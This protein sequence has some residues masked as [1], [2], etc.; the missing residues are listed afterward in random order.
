MANQEQ[1]VQTIQQGY[2]FKGAYIT[3]GGGMFNTTSVPNTLIKLPL[4]TLNR[5]GL[6]AGATGTGK[7]KSIQ[8]I[9]ERLSENGISVL[10][11]DIKGDFSGVAEAGNSNPKIEERVAAIGNTWNP[12][13][14]PVELMSISTQ[15]GV[16]LRAT[17]T[18]FG[19]V[20]ISKILD[21]NDTQQGVVAM[22]FKFCDDQQLAL[23]DLPDFKKVLQFLTNEGKSIFEKEYGAISPATVGTILRKVVELE[24]QGAE[25]FFGETSFDVND[26]LRKDE[27]GYGYINIVRL[28]DIQDKPKLFSTFMLSLLAEVYSKFPERGDVEQPELI[29]FLDEAHLIFDNASNALK[30]QLEAIIK[31]I[32]SKGVGIFFCTQNP[33]DIPESILAQL[34]L[35]VQHALRAFTAK[36]RQAI[37]LVADNY[38]MTDFYKVEDLITQLGIGEAFVT[39]LNEKGIPTPL[40][41]CMM[42]APQSRMDVLNEDEMTILIQKSK[43]YRKY[44]D[45]ID[46][47]SAFEIL[48]AKMEKLQEQELEDEQV[49]AAAKAQKLP[50]GKVQKTTL[51]KVLNSTVTK[52]IARTATTTLT[53]GLLGALKGM[54]K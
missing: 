8:A 24:Q 31:L 14:Y 35:K 49:K 30:D 21:L 36:D 12:K 19:P 9:S 22:V 2:T 15:D 44:K 16:R 47:E 26:L 13:A 43:L 41:H 39:A 17:V 6:I 18:E 34:G 11:M 23:V 46:P 53:R 4:K 29:I 32:R 42:S 38:P 20:L 25:L 50:S 3:I 37:K 51:E 5:H 45:V 52:Q 48:S 27:N 40:V 10:M 7:T 28:T 1:F 54:F 33:N